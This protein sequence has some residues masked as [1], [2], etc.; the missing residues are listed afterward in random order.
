MKPRHISP[1]VQGIIFAFIHMSNE[2]VCFFWLFTR[3]AGKEDF[4][5]WA[6]LYNALAFVPQALW[7]DLTD[8]HRE[9]DICTPGLVMLGAG[10]LLPYDPVSLL[11]I[12][13]GNSMIHVAGAQSTLR[14]ADGRMGPS[15]VFVGGGSFGVIAGQ[16]L[17]ASMPGK[18]ASVC[19][20]FLAV[21][22]VLSLLMRNTDNRLLDASGFAHAS[23]LG[24]GC[25]AALA[26]MTVA[27]RSY[28][29]YAIP[30]GWNDSS[31]EKVLLFCFMGFGKAAGGYAADRFGA[32]RT[33]VWSLVL[34]LPFVLLGNE[35]MS[36]SLAGVTLFSMTMS[37]SLGI[38]VSVYPDNP[39]I[40][41]GITTIGLFLGSLPFF[42]FG[43]GTLAFRV[44]VT[45]LL[46]AVT[47][48]CFRLCGSNADNKGET[49]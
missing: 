7:G 33:A 21:S 26:F 39:G 46:T 42:L 49:T 10:L 9:L 5:I 14:G 47:I 48:C 43:P 35:S 24:A 25:V 32:R 13:C 17:A 44:T 4:W 22:A 18:G 6:L 11:L 28:A 34:C 20:A 30:T 40:C 23:G 41:F 37:V 2:I 8:R 12:T 1:H 29:G 15:G 45:A 36:V 27:A 3:C 38:L 19:A 31:L 16:L